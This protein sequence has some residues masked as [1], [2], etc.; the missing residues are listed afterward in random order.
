MTRWLHLGAQGCTR[1][2]S[3][4]ASARARCS[5]SRRTRWDDRTS[6]RRLAAARQPGPYQCLSV[7]N[8]LRSILRRPSRSLSATDTQGATPSVRGDAVQA[9]PTRHDSAIFPTAGECPT[10]RPR[11]PSQPGRFP[12]PGRLIRMGRQIV[13]I[14]A[15]ILRFLILTAHTNLMDLRVGTNTNRYGAAGW[16]T[17]LQG[18]AKAPRHPSTPRGLSVS[19][20]RRGS[21]HLD[22][23]V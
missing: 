19:C 7:S 18:G 8:H 14:Y 1:S 9:C 4:S 16:R 2:P 22:L 13:S 17:L 10:A 11:A 20:R 21:T 6:R 23:R 15:A 5:G 3:S 12:R